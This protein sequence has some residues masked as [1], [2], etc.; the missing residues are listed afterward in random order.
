MK[1]S[2]LQT[3]L[4][5]HLYTWSDNHALQAAQMDFCCP[6]SATPPTTAP[7]AAA[8]SFASWFSHRAL[9]TLWQ[10]GVQMRARARPWP[11]V[12]PVGQSLW[13]T[14]ANGLRSAGLSPS[15]HRIFSQLSTTPSDFGRDLRYQSRVVV[16]SRGILRNCYES[17]PSRSVAFLR[18]RTWQ[19]ARR[20]HALRLA[21]QRS[22]RKNHG[23]RA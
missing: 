14:A 13:T 22:R 20:Q 5:D 15:N 11:K 21:R 23:D 9:Q 12:L 4:A 19:S 8:R 16:P 3:Q 18:C 10:A 7:D 2:D 1:H 17:C 6:A